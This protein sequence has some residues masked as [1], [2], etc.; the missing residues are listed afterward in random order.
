MKQ[1]SDT[2]TCDMF[3]YFDL[4]AEPYKPSKC[5]R[6]K[7]THHGLSRTKGYRVGN[8]TLARRFNDNN[9]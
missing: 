9:N 2:K 5:E 7:K 8:K 4:L 3:D 1:K 6:L